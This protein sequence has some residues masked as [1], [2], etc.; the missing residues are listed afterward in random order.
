MGEEDERKEG[1]EKT[2]E[3]TQ[4]ITTKEEIKTRL[5]EETTTTH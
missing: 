1:D 2:E 3:I 5:H 4:T